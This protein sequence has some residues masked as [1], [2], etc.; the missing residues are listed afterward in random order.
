MIPQLSPELLLLIAEHF[1]RPIPLSQ[2]PRPSVGKAI[3]AD[4]SALVNMMKSS[5]VSFMFLNVDYVG[6]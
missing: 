6:S 1:E 4:N 3:K 5:K 2:V